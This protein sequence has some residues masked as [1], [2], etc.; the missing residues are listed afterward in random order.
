MIDSDILPK[1]FISDSFEKT[2]VYRLLAENKKRRIALAKSFA[3]FGANVLLIRPEISFGEKAPFEFSEDEGISVLSVHIDSK[4][5]EKLLPFREAMSFCSALSDNSFC[6][7]GIFLPDAVICGGSFCFGYSAAEKIA[8]ET[9]AVLITEFCC[10]PKGILSKS[11]LAF[12]ISPMLTVLKRYMNLAAE[13]SDAVLGFCPEAK[14]HFSGAHG[15]F[16]MYLPPVFGK[17]EPSSDA[18]SLYEKLFSYKGGKTFV[19]GCALP[20]EFGFGIEELISVSSA[21]GDKFALVFI[22]DGSKK[23]RYQRMVSEKGI[24]NVFFLEGAKKEDFPFILSAADG[25]FLSENGFIKG[26]APETDF[27][28]A[29]SSERPVIASSEHWADFFRESGGTVITKPRNKESLRL[30]IRALLEMTAPDRDIL[31]AANKE[32]FDKHSFDIFA[33]EYFSLIDN[34]SSQKENRKNI[35]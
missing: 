18:F 19:L 2:A 21:F 11:G 32:F 8:K 23:G 33:K 9:G 4:R 24:T 29:L 5:T 15:F 35:S 1:K 12:G 16:P 6:L 3:A 22:S 28:T 34:L 26:S 20:L 14:K 10:E 7:G 13:N 25:V 17:K 27:F 31:G 30:G